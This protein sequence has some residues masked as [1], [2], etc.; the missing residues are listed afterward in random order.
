FGD[1]GIPRAAQMRLNR[2]DRREVDRRAPAR[3]VDIGGRIESDAESAIV[4]RASEVS[5]GKQL[6]TDGAEDRHEG[7]DAPSVHC[8]SAAGCGQVGRKRPACGD[9]VKAGIESDGGD[10]IFRG[11][12]EESAEEDGGVD[13]QRALVVV[14]RRKGDESCQCF[15]KVT[16]DLLAILKELR[17][18]LVEFPGAGAD[19]E[20][21]ITLDR[22]G[23]VKAQ[24]N[25]GNVGSGSDSVFILHTSVILAENEIDTWP[26]V[27]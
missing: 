1:K 27:A 12:A 18:A 11:A 13:D 20:A 21:A 5:A 25:I 3:D 26:D 24:P 17:R 4:A 19:D 14:V 9:H 2:R 23:P 16:R 6:P 7:V 15:D 22:D 10:V 8:A